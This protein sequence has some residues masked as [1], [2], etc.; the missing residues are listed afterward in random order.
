[1]RANKTLAIT[2][3][4]L[5][6]FTGITRANAQSKPALTVATNQTEAKPAD[7]AA[8][9]KKSQSDVASKTAKFGTIAK[10]DEAYKTAL[11]A[12][13]LDDALKQVGKTTAFKGTVTK[14]FSPA[15][16]KLLILNFDKDYKTALTAMVKSQDFDKFPDLKTIVGK[17]VVVSGKFIDYQGRAEMPLTSPDQIKLVEEAK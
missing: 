1:M 6:A 5:A 15:G 12:H 14:T 3:A 17:E 2:L 11:D 10:T 16:G 9:D 4:T 7:G 13:A 8:Q